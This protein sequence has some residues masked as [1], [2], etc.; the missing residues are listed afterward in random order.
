MV[1]DNVAGQA[2][3]VLLAALLQLVQGT[4]A[5]KVGG[6]PVGVQGIGRR[7]GFRVAGHLLDTLRCHGTFPDTD[8]PQRIESLAGQAGQFLVG[9]LGQGRDG[10]PV[11]DAQLVKPHVDRFGEQDAAGHPV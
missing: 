6:H 11:A 1:G 3:T 9:D 7:F 2:D 5:T 8:Q 10:T 4:F